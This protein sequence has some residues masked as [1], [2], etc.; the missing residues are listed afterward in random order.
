LIKEWY[1]PKEIYFSPAQ[2]EWLLEVLT[3]LRAGRYPL[4]PSNYTDLVQRHFY[5]K[6]GFE[7]PV[8]IAAE[9]MVRMQACGLDGYLAIEHYAE[10][11]EIEEIAKIRFLDIDDIERRIRKAKNYISYHREVRPWVDKKYKDKE[12]GE[13]KI[14]KGMTYREWRKRGRF[15]RSVR[16]NDTHCARTI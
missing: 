4:E 3:M 13:D 5:A 7:T 8:E 2:V 16:R 6:G 10:G 14:N 15:L 12:T 9:L 11:I 1:S